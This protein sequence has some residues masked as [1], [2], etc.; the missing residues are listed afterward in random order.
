MET[1]DGDVFC[2]NYVVFISASICRSK[3]HDI[4][5]INSIVI[6]INTLLD[7]S[8]YFSITWIAIHW[9]CVLA[10]S[11]Y[12]ARIQIKLLTTLPFFF[13]KFLN[14]LTKNELNLDLYIIA[15]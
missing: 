2:D 12:R 8:K 6:E 7:G 11:E 15:M 14:K 10:I 4:R 9:N 3:F 13:L 5:A 1:M